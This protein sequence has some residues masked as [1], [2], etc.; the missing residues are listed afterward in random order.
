MAKPTVNVPGHFRMPTETAPAALSLGMK[1]LRALCLGSVL[2]LLAAAIR[3]A[4]QPLT[5]TGAP[6]L[7]FFGAVLLA[8]ILG[9]ALA[10]ATTSM[11]GGALAVYLFVPATGYRVFEIFGQYILF[12]AEGASVAWVTHGFFSSRK[13]AQRTMAALQASEQRYQLALRATSDLVWDWS[14]AEDRMDF[15]EG[16]RTSLGYPSEACHGTR[17]WWLAHIGDEDRERVALSLRLA[18]ANKQA[19]WAQEYRFA[20]FDGSFI[21]VLD[22]GYIVFDKAGKP[23]RMIG[24]M[25]DITRRR[26]DARV[27]R[28]AEARLRLVTDAL[29]ALVGYLDPNGRHRFMNAEYE[30]WFLK[31]R[32]DLLNI[33]LD[34][35]LG[36]QARNPRINA[37]ITSAMAGQT[38]RVEET[39]LHAV[40]GEVATMQTFVPDFDDRRQVRGLVCLVHDISEQKRS[41]RDL[42]ES[43]EHYRLLAEVVPQTIFEARSDGYFSYA[44][45]QWSRYSGLVAGEWSGDGWVRAVHPNHR[46]QVLAGWKGAT[47]AGHEYETELLLFRAQDSTYRWH[48]LRALALRDA[49]GDVR[50]WIGCLVDIHERKQSEQELQNLADFIPQLAWIADTQGEVSWLNQRWYDYTGKEPAQLQGQGWLMA[51]AQDHRERVRRSLTEAF[52]KEAAFEATFPLYSGQQTCRWFLTRAVPIFDDA[53][54][55]SRWFATSTDIN[56]QLETQTRLQRAQ[57]E[58][59]T[60]VRAR[61]EFMSI[62]SHELKTPLTSLQLLAQMAQR[63]LERDAERACETPRVR[64][65]V[66]QTEKS[67]ERL[68]RLVD[69][70]LDSSR[71]AMGKL[72]FKLEDFDLT[73]LVQEVVERMVPQVRASGGRVALVASRPARGRWDRFRIEQVVINLMTNAMRYG[74]GTPIEIGVDVDDEAAWFRIRDHG[75][76]IAPDHQERIFHQYE[77]ATPH[78]SISGLGLGLFI[79]REIVERHGGRIELQSD[80]GRGAAFSV[81][82]P[83]DG[84]PSAV[85]HSR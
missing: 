46:E 76:G 66:S 74:A 14:A 85:P 5:G 1:L 69:D 20:R 63:N 6:F 75:P 65:L 70:M 58:L 39:L 10:G 41:E 61:D 35:L 15:G 4:L 64:K 77:R 25:Q 34:E 47:H 55:L 43:E 24:A 37:A 32:A 21:D 16:L 27:L 22:K 13:A 38:V 79:C 44:N 72:S 60:A 78:S 56:D 59:E 28:E 31:P 26:A 84:P 42:R 83:L 62:A 49:K 73:E 23:L 67:V 2:S 45:K 19:L 40:R 68:N 82:L 3:I 8:S 81:R 80:V 71:I 48:I 53:G 18:Y 54:R 57:N 9:G 30:R 50:K 12:V 51:I 36:K 29:P 17:D 11:M 7:V 52:R 33:T